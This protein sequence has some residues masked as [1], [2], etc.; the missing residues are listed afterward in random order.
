MAFFFRELPV[1]YSMPS[2]VINH[3]NYNTESAVLRVTF[4]SGIVYEYKAVPKKVYE[5]MKA[6][7]SK[8]K[9][10]NENIKGKFLFEKINSAR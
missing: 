3:F 7:A 6:S 1:K 8:G 5:K 9:F 2:T 4:V 10:L